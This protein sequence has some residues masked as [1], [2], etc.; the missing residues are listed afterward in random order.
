VLTICLKSEPY[1]K[2]IIGEYQAG[3]RMGRSIINQ[4]FTVKQM[5]EKC[6]ENN[7]KVYQIY[8][9][10]KQCYD[11][12]N[13]EKLYKIM[14][15]AGIPGKLIRLVR[16]TMKDEEAQVKVQTQLTEPLKIRQGL[17]HGD[18][19][20]TSLCHQEVISQC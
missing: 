19:L 16:A 9:D 17:K 2:N 18:G 12:I 13:H 4:L 1:T 7:I 5:L 14:Y 15:G 20:A 11:S 6:W 3:F 8:V 10:F